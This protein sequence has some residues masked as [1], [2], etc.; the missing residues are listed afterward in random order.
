MKE[1]VHITKE[2]A[3]ADRMRPINLKIS[4]RLRPASH[5]QEEDPDG[6]AMALDISEK[7]DNSLV[8][9]SKLLSITLVK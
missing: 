2:Q 5:A 4:A 8:I 3:Q 1:P 9:S 7:L 6:S